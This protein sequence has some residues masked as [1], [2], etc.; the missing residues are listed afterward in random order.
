MFQF[1]RFAS[2]PYAFRH[3]FP[4]KAGKGSPIRTSQDHSLVASSPGLIAGSN[5]LHR[6]WTPSH[7]PH[8][9]SSLTTP[10]SDR[11]I[12]PASASTSTV[13]RTIRA[14]ATRCTAKRNATVRQPMADKHLR[15]ITIFA[16]NKMQKP[17]PIH[18]SKNWTQS[19]LRHPHA[20]RA[21]TSA[22][23]QERRRRSSQRAVNNIL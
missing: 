17:L 13:P 22:I 21:V 10:T 4:R 16:R 6:L 11:P 18:L 9:L 2:I 20:M 19:N 3:G 1:P 7:P 15:C 23:R 14:G 12:N 5:V 8:A